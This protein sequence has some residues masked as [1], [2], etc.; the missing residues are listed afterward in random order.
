MIAL[1]FSAFASDGQIPC[2]G[3]TSPPPE[4]TTA[5]TTTDG[6]IDC[7]LTQAA[8]TIIQSILLLP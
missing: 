3:I 5:E 7:G 6:H 2:E 1:A 8:L 4:S